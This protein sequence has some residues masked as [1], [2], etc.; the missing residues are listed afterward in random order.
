MKRVLLD[1]SVYGK[2]VEEPKVTQLLVKKI[3]T[4]FVVY[5][6]KV[7]R[8]ELRETP[9][10]KRFAGKNKR[11]L[12]LTLYDTLIRKDHHELKKNKLVETL[13]RDYYKG[14][15]RFGGSVS[16]KKMVNDLLII[17]I[18]T[19]YQLDVIVSDDERTMLSS[20]AIRAYKRVNKTYGL[21][22][23]V[24]KTYKKF[25]SELQGDLPL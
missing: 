15:R 14:Y 8:E 9:K 13:A 11:I 12:L 16:D 7:I 21:K 5:G 2:L 6:S 17:S 3:P 19:I 22:N 18:A 4:E 23:P 1:T 10:H 24:F 20:S 25:I